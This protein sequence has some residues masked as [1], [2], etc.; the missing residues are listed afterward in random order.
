MRLRASAVVL[1]LG[2]SLALDCAVFG[3]PIAGVVFKH[4]SQV[5]KSIG[6]PPNSDRRSFKHKLQ[7][8]Y[9]VVDSSA[10]EQSAHSKQLPEQATSAASEAAS[11]ELN[12]A[13]G[14]LDDASNKEL[15]VRHVFVVDLEPQHAGAYQCEAVSEA[16]A[17][18]AQSTVFVRVLDEPPKFRHTFAAA[19]HEPRADIS[20]LCSAHANPLPEIRWMVDGAPVVESTRTHSGDFVTK[21]G[22][23]ISFVN[24]TSAQVD[25]SGLYECIAD[26]GL[27]RVQHSAQVSV[28]GPVNVKRMDNVTVFAGTS[29]Q[30]R[31]PVVG[32]PVAEIWWQRNADAHAKR[33]PTNHRQRVFENGTLV[34]EHVDKA[35]A[36][37][38]L[39]ACF[40]RSAV[41]DAVPAGNEQARLAFGGVY[42]SI[43]ARPSIE[44]F[45]VSRS[46]REGQ[47]ASIMCTISSGDLPIAIDWFRDGDR[48]G[49][50]A[51]GSVRANRVSDYSSTLLFEPLSMQHSANYTCLARNDAGAASYTIPV[52]VLGECR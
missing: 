34:V 49:P 14:E 25:D 24:I 1:E 35:Q 45:V 37:D 47:R 4:N 22:L 2:K 23:V 16:R 7:S 42:V 3:W 51:N 15:T 36:D 40:A 50:D 41:S 43:R 39:Y 10:L 11:E 31:C 44:P 9:F 17:R 52:V 18:T 13:I 6:H 29:L 12:S 28:V 20:L 5:I 46:L 26:N 33:L 38:G 48:L 27:A 8:N 30:L 32:A 21:D 19:T